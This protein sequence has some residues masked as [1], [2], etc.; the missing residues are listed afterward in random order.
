MAHI[1][2]DVVGYWYRN[3][4]LIL[5]ANVLEVLRESWIMLEQLLFQGFIMVSHYFFFFFVEISKFFLCCKNVA[6]R[7]RIL[8]QFV[9]IYFAIW[10][11]IKNNESL[12]LRRIKLYPCRTIF[13][14][15]SLKAQVRHAF[16]QFILRRHFEFP[17]CDHTFLIKL[18]GSS[19][20][21]FQVKVQALVKEGLRAC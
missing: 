4:Q 10:E 7:I 16:H 18:G 6:G 17:E 1:A 12:F 20:A 5:L 14:L 13:F 8:P 2:D 19:L 9:E 21:L 15:N 3:H 11:S